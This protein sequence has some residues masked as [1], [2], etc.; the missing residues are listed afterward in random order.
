MILGSPQFVSSDAVAQAEAALF[1]TVP[2]DPFG[3]NPLLADLAGFQEVG[4]AIQQFEPL[5]DLLTSNVDGGLADLGSTDP[6]DADGSNDQF[7]TLLLPSDPSTD[8]GSSPFSVAGDQDLLAFAQ[9]QNVNLI[10]YDSGD[11]PGTSFGT[12]IQMNLADADLGPIIVSLD[13]SVGVQFT[14]HYRLTL[15]L[16]GNGVYAGTGS[17]QSYAE[18]DTTASGTLTGSVSLLELDTVSDAALG[19]AG[20]QSAG[21]ALA[22]T[23]SGKLYL[24]KL[25]DPNPDWLANAVQ[26]VSAA[27]PSSDVFFSFGLDNPTG[28]AADESGVDQVLDTIST[29]TGPLT[30]A[31]AGLGLIGGIGGKVLSDV[32]GGGGGGAIVGAVAGGAVLGPV[33]AII[34]G[35]VGGGGGSG[36]ISQYAGDVLGA[37]YGNYIPTADTIAQGL[38]ISP[39]GPMTDQNLSDETNYDQGDVPR[40][41]IYHYG[42][43]TLPNDADIERAEYTWSWPLTPV[44]APAVTTVPAGG[45]YASAPGDLIPVTDNSGGILEFDPTSPNAIITLSPVNG[46]IQVT[47]A[48][49][50]ADGTVTDDPPLIFDGVTQV[51]ETAQGGHNTFDVASGVNVPVIYTSTGEDNVLTQ[52]GPGTITTAGGIIQTG[53]G[54]NTIM[55]SGGP[56]IVF[57]GTGTN[58][59]TAG[60]AYVSALGAT[61]I[62]SLGGLEARIGPGTYALK[63]LQAGDQIISQTSP[64]TPI[65]QITSLTGAATSTPTPNLVGVPQ[66]AVGADAGGSGT[67]TV[68]NPDQ[69]VAYTAVPFGAAFTDGVRV[70][71]ADLNNDGAPELIAGTGPGVANQV[72]VL[73]GTTHQQLLSFNPFETTFTGGI[74]VAVGDVNGD[75]VPDLIVTPDQSGGPIVAVYD[76]A[77]L[78]KGQ[79]TQLARFFGINDPN[80]RGGARAAVGDI[81]GDGF[82]D[83]IV[84]AGFGGG[85]RVA[86]YSGASVATN[87][88]TELLP[89]FFAF[90]SS[91]R[92]GAYVTAGDLTGKGYA[93]LI[94][95]AGPGGG[96]RVRAVDPAVLLAAAGDFSSLDDSTV[97]G[98]G[99]ADFFAGD[100]TNRGGVRVGIADLD[101]SNQAGLVVGSG[102]GAGTTVTTYTGKAILADAGAPTSDF[103]LDAFP[104]FSGGVF[105]G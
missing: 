38:N 13:G 85:P 4:A 54:P 29:V 69:S 19:L 73:D 98:A 5:F 66:V 43:G 97:S 47:R 15:G 79:V 30:E 55:T 76:G 50:N 61:T 104:G 70:A 21:F 12:S 94:F 77:A 31:G 49:A 59:I 40:D 53:N 82:G 103:A 48:T 62:N 23:T 72:V 96:P 2:G 105:V 88:P 39:S 81:N 37:S 83:V 52:D 14:P 92:N 80:F 16:D 24:Q 33:G 100:P 63:G 25:L 35:Y 26:P 75:G 89:D 74:F 3:N 46:G 45:S 56:G 90:E 78:G 58:T 6:D 91:L 18:L 42:P 27:G 1:A 68:Y 44:T 101:A 20:S 102:T 64:A 57:A 17:G 60:N 51:Q 28:Q 36:A 84:S 99:L 67:V 41:G 65:G 71:V 95:G 34:G 8:G 10:T 93:D 7:T 32:S 87:T 86:I 9:G 11:I 22:P